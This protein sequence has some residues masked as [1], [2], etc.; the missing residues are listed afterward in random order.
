MVKNRQ[1]VGSNLSLHPIYE[2]IMTVFKP[3]DAGASETVKIERELVRHPD[4]S[5][6][7]LQLCLAAFRGGLHRHAH[8]ELT[9]IERGHGLRW[10]GDSVEPFGD[11]DLVLLG[12]DLAHVWLTPRGG[13]PLRCTATVL[14]FPADWAAATGLPELR[15]LD[16]L[17]ARA[18]HGLAIEGAARREVQAV[19]ARLAK[20]DAPRRV[21]VLIEVL[22]IL[23]GCMRDHPSELRALSTHAP[24][25]NSDNVASRMQRHQ[26]VDR[27]LR[28]VQAHLAEELRV[29][30]A[31]EVAGISPAAFARYFRRE[32]GKGFVDFVNDAR[33]SWAA[34]RLLQG[35]ESIADIAHGCGFLSLSNFGDQFRRR[36]GASPRDYRRHVLRR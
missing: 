10:A 28:W 4:A 16:A 22:A 9:W 1:C 25:R 27:L 26:R 7:C 36:Y 11:G 34:L 30:D 6:R 8:A 15:G 12:A 17:M 19:M 13:E 2:Q 24:S 23:N 29:S 5:M 20:A 14:Q 31:A 35:Q 33:C 3:I 21:A 18:A 32:V